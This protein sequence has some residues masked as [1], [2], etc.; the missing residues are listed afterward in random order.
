MSATTYL[1]ETF[2]IINCYQCQMSF[3]V[4][5][6]VHQRWLDDHNQWF[7]C[8]AGHSQHYIGETAE[9]K[10]REQL[11]QKK[12]EIE[13]LEAQRNTARQNAKH[14]ERSAAITRGR[15]RKLKE[16]IA[17]GLCPCCRRP[18][19]NLLAHMQHKHPSY[20]PTKGQEE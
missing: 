7:Y 13:Q 2:T 8:P 9:Q 19:A 10:L 5:A 6:S 20:R 15:H 11:A 1:T 17:A 18:F 14:F 3:A 16:R 12:H 4:P